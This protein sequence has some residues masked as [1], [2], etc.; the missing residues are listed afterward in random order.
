MRVL[1]G[2][3]FRQLSCGVSP[4]YLCSALA[5]RP[6]TSWAALQHSGFIFVSSSS[7]LCS[8]QWSRLSES[9]NSSGAAGPGPCAETETSTLPQPIRSA[10]SW[11]SWS[12]LLHVLPRSSVPGL[13]GELWLP[14]VLGGPYTLPQFPSLERSQQ[15]QALA[16]SIEGSF[17]QFILLAT[18][19]RPS[20]WQA[21]ICW[22]KPG[23]E[24]PTD[25]LRRAL[26]Q[27]IKIVLVPLFFRQTFIDDPL[28]CA[29]WRSRVLA[30]QEPI[31]YW[32]ASV[33]TKS[34]AWENSIRPDR[35][36]VGG[37][38][39]ETLHSALARAK[40][41]TFYPSLKDQSEFNK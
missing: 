28:L 11:D 32:G 40:L 3:I 5:P 29:W 19:C 8:P 37:M 41:L 20:E 17:L 18:P 9:R 6:A 33:K 34:W 39:K 14:A 22:A 23:S 16:T 36:I 10:C 15:S 21:G 27:K 1:Y 38:E 13:P 26:V 4:K 30:P 31:V 25:S 12:V 2:L 35:P 24:T 7:E